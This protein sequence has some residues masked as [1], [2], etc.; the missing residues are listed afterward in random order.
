[1]SAQKLNSGKIKAAIFLIPFALILCASMPYILIVLRAF[2]PSVSI[3]VTAFHLLF[4]LSLSAVCGNLMTEI[5]LSLIEHAG[6][7][8]INKLLYKGK[9]LFP[10]RPLL[11]VIIFIVFYIILTQIISY[12][13]PVQRLVLTV[14]SIAIL[15]NARNF[16]SS[17]IRYISGCYII[18]KNKF[19]TVFS[20]FVNDKDSFCVIT[21]DGT[22]IVTGINTADFDYSKLE[23]EFSKN[24]LKSRN[25][26]THK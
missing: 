8:E 15:L 17:R 4:I 16:I 21:D 7:S 11:F 2:S 12:Q 25:G 24:S 1:M 6:K 9:I 13:S 19:H 5:I 3:A 26:T 23:A 10:I 22:R 20:Y 14:P 18:Y